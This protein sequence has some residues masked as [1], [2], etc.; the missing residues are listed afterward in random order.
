MSIFLKLLLSLTWQRDWWQGQSWWDQTVVP[1]WVSCSKQ[2]GYH[3][4][5]HSGGWGG[6]SSG[7]WKYTYFLCVTLTLRWGCEG[8]DR[9]LHQFSLLYFS[10]SNTREELLLLHKCIS[11]SWNK[12][13]L[14]ITGN[15]NLP[16][17]SHQKQNRLACEHRNLEL[18]TFCRWGVDRSCQL[19]MCIGN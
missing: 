4:P 6:W 16:K 3:L 13:V 15:G 5:H 9:K 12:N 11:L 2:L 14:N 7:N 19:L 18:D 1:G 17:Q 10:I 8:C